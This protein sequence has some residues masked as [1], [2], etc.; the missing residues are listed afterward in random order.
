LAETALAALR[1]IWKNIEGKIMVNP[2]TRMLDLPEVVD[3]P[4]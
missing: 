3:Y 1:E 4:V 2:K